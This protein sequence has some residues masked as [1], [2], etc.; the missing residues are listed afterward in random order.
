MKHKNI[1]YCDFRVLHHI[2]H[3]QAT[4]VTLHN[5]AKCPIQHSQVK[6]IPL[7]FVRQFNRIYNRFSNLKLEC[8]SLE[9]P[10]FEDLT[11]SIYKIKRWP[12]GLMYLPHNPGFWTRGLFSLGCVVSYGTSID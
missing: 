3:N 12:N 10:P 4:Q 1:I 11:Q 7:Q 2:Q 8:C 6:L 9:L 5:Q